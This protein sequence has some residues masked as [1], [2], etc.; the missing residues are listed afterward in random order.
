MEFDWDPAKNRANIAKHG[1]SFDFAIRIFER[2]IVVWTD[3]RLD[4]GEVR[5]GGLGEI[6]GRVYFVAWT[7]R[8]PEQCRMISARKA[9]DREKKRYEAES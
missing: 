1:V 8:G 9:N 7:M 4:Y 5:H 3:S 2:R 6:D